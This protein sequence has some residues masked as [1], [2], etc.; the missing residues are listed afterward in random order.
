MAGGR[1]RDPRVDE[2]VFAA[3]TELL[4]EKGYE[5]VGLQAVAR[6]AG[7][8][9]SSVYRRWP[10]KAHLVHELLFTDDIQVPLEDADVA[11]VVRAMVD[12][13]IAQFSRPTALAATPG[14]LAEFHRDPDLRRVLT[15]RIETAFRQ[16]LRAALAG[17]VRPGVDPDVLMDAIAGAVLFA[18][19]VDPRSGVAGVP[20]GFADQLID[21][22][23][24]GVLPQT[25][26]MRRSRS[27]NSASPK[28]SRRSSGSRPQSQR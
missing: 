12:G 7:V 17:N 20:G 28:T 25:R 2:A 4:L 3:A 21:L 19:F 11:S 15:D 13:T 18:L 14:L 6:R 27:A 26:Q 5:G 22:L 9:H 23:L 24:G 16:R 8:G 1:P 10:S